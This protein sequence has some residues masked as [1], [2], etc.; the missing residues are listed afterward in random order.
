MRNA[1]EEKIH[2]PD[3]SFCKVCETVYGVNRGIYNTI[4]SYFYQKGNKD[5]V[6]R[7]QMILSFLQSI[8]TSQANLNK[9][10]S[11]KFGHGGLVEKLDAFTSM[12]K[13]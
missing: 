7:R 12:C 1:V 10:S 11:F 6:V 9:K 13:K 8:G 3:F 4:D 2:L 5:I